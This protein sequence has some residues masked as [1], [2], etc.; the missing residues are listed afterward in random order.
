MDIKNFIIKNFQCISVYNFYSKEGMFTVTNS[1]QNI[2]PAFNKKIK[3][4][5]EV[6]QWRIKKLYNDSI[7]R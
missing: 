3:E 6:G 7:K 1:H 5:H 2:D 4:P